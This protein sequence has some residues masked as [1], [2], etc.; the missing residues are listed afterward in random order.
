MSFKMEKFSAWDKKS[1]RGQFKQAWEDHN[2]FC[3]STFDSFVERIMLEYAETLKP[4]RI[5]SANEIKSDWMNE[6]ALNMDLFA[7]LGESE[8][9]VILNAEQLT[10][11]VQDVF[12]NYSNNLTKKFLLLFKNGNKSGTKFLNKLLKS[13]CSMGLTVEAP[14]FWDYN[15][16]FL[17]YLENLGCEVD[18]GLGRV[19]FQ[20]K[21][22]GPSEIAQFAIS[23]SQENNGSTL[24]YEQVQKV[25][26]KKAE[27]VFSLVKKLA[28][29]DWRGFYHALEKVTHDSDQFRSGVVFLQKHFMKVKYPMTYIKGNRKPTKFDQ[30][31]E[32][33]GRMWNKSEIDNVLNLLSDLEMLSKQAPKE[34]PMIIRDRIVQNKKGELGSPFNIL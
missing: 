5:M 13:E 22:M 4:Y 14:K 31:I 9:F 34:L 6:N 20:G 24:T 23:L 29:K 15:K 1:I 19:S 8:N 2:I 25:L 10:V 21:D 16:Y 3:L 32:R 12:I 26:D 28:A 30:E 33:V 18:S 17:F 27:D 11:D 7:S